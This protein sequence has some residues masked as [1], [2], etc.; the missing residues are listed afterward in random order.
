MR[1]IG[2]L[3]ADKMGGLSQSFCLQRMREARLDSTI[4][5]SRYFSNSAR[6]D[7]KVSG[8]DSLL[9]ILDRF[10][11]DDVLLFSRLSK[12]YLPMARDAE[13]RH[14]D[15][16]EAR[17]FGLP[18]HPVS[19]PMTRKAVQAAL[20]GASMSFTVG[21][22][23][24]AMGEGEPMD[25]P[26]PENGFEDAAPPRPSVGILLSGKLSA[27]T[28]GRCVDEFRQSGMDDVIVFDPNGRTPGC[29]RTLRELAARIEVG[30]RSEDSNDE[31][32]KGFDDRVVLCVT[33]AERVSDAC[34]SITVRRGRFQLFGRDG[35]SKTVPAFRFNPSEIQAYGSFAAYAGDFLKAMNIVFS[36]TRTVIEPNDVEAAS[37]EEP[38]PEEAATGGGPVVTVV[39]LT[40]NRT[41]V[42][43]H[44]L[45]ALCDNLK[46]DGRIRYCIC[47]DRSEPGHVEALEKTLS[48]HGV[49]DYVVK[50]TND[51]AWGLGAS[52]N[53][54]LHE[55]FSLSPLALTAEDDFLLMRELDLTP[56]AKAAIENDVAG[57]RLAYVR[58]KPVSS[59]HTLT[60]VEPSDIPGFVRVAG[61]NI[62]NPQY[63]YVFNNQVMLRHKRVYDRI[64]YYPES[65]AHEEMEKK[66][67]AAYVSA[68]NAGRS[69]HC[70]VLYPDNL[71]TDTYDNGLFLHIGASTARHGYKVP[72]EYAALNSRE[73]DAKLR[74]A[75]CDGK[76]FFRI[77]I[78]AYNVSTYI[79]RCLRS[80]E[81]Q[82]FTNFVAAVCDDMSTDGTAKVLDRLGQKYDWLT[83][84]K[85][86]RKLFN[87]GARNAALAAVD[88]KYTVY[89]DA[90]DFFASNKVLE[91]IYNAIVRNGFPDAVRLSYIHSVPGM[92][93]RTVY[94]RENTPFAVASAM[95]GAPW[96]LCVKS[97]K[98]L[99]FP[100]DINAQ[101]DTVHNIYQADNLDSVVVM[102]RPAVI[103]ADGNPNSVSRHPDRGIFAGW[104]RAAAKIMELPEKHAWMK[105]AKQGA[106]RRWF[107]RSVRNKSEIIK[108][109][110]V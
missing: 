56:L 42:A 33:E 13:M 34:A 23:K 60:V 70:Q 93:D 85:A 26:E 49:A 30:R 59:G 75:A 17:R 68:F 47:D 106:I 7:F 79:E 97:S 1:K 109:I 36:M 64:G 66:V 15:D 6:S 92:P 84:V 82:T 98:V 53:N 74:G 88:A 12:A 48:D 80:V 69:R 8:A 5:M 76:P 90:D 55:A 19:E 29:A 11:D 50:S 16:G 20:D 100:D 107:D 39:F 94:L 9:R 105:Q 73:A 54:G 14:L 95:W 63:K 87:G 24:A 104:F 89:L 57:I 61:G 2:V 3:T 37:A 18:L 91:D 110:G 28:V 102:D 108:S 58:T 41:A 32:P 40:H 38:R 71:A 78:P 4:V 22:F 27:Q 45:G 10:R 21:G 103:Y 43:C 51:S 35:E 44:C 46:F 83:V 67:G 96:A 65:C 62:G 101:V 72:A 77:I 52:M 25:V 31:A 99:P 81:G 86:G